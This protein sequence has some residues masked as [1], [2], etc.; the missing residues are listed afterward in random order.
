M[1]ELK[2]PIEL[3][4]YPRESSGSG[5]YSIATTK[6]GGARSVSWDYEK[7]KWV[8]CSLPVGTI[9]A[10]GMTLYEKDLRRLGLGY[11]I[12]EKI[13]FQ[14][15]LD[16]E[17]DLEDTARTNLEG[18]DSWFAIPIPR[19]IIL[20]WDKYPLVRALVYSTACALV[21]WFAQPRG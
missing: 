6:N 21:I 16:V 15:G 14:D 11:I 10:S 13:K 20:L 2:Y 7:Q 19:S 12:D 9:M 1:S 8:K 4:V 17:D 3:I 18:K 5:A